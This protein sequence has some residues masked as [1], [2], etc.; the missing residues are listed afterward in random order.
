MS[1][2]NFLKCSVVQLFTCVCE[3]GLSIDLTQ[4]IPSIYLLYYNDW[5]TS[6]VKMSISTFSP[7]SSTIHFAANTE[8]F[9]YWSS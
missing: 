2:F 1:P 4:I 6:M 8:Y 5:I 7:Y 3:L 9:L